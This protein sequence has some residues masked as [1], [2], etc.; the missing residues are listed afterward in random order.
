MGCCTSRDSESNKPAVVW[1]DEFEKG[2]P[3]LVG[4]R[5]AITGSTTGT[6]FVAALA[7]ARKG[8]ELLLLNRASQR[9]A[10]AEAKL[11]QECPTAI[12]H[13]VPCDLMDFASVRSAAKAVSDLCPTPAG[14][15]VLSCNA[16]IMAFPDKATKDGFDMQMQTNHLSH[17][18]L[19]KELLPALRAAA[20]SKGEARIVNHSSGAR[21]GG[22]LEA[23]FFGKNGGE[24]GGDSVSACFERYH[25][26][27]LA[28]IVF[29]FALADKLAAK[30][31]TG[32][33]VFCCTPGI[34]ATGLIDN[35]ESSGTSLGPMKCVF[36]CFGSAVIQSQEDGTM[37]LLHAMAFKVGEDLQTG[38]LLTPS[39]GGWRNP[40]EAYGPVRIS[41]R[42]LPG[43]ERSAVCQDVGAQELLW[44]ESEKAIG[45]S[46]VV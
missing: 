33:K 39:Q 8:A 24:L 28:N 17:F 6:G 3:S 14:L 23:K 19:V 34:A 43:G 46:F 36:H 42:P 10:E 41:R 26:T 21:F 1:Y 12:I 25:Q 45:E 4:K 22:P 31:E 9:V 11:R 35:L 40:A 37:P 32:I 38:D 7:C 16:G 5:I 27:K 20:S 15:D 18:L 44:H 2:L 29:A 30:N 13:N